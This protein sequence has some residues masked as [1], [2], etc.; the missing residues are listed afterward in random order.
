MGAQRAGTTWWYGLLA[1][2]P[3]IFHSPGRPKELHYFDGFWNHPL[4]PADVALYE[5]YFPRPPGA[6][7][8]EWTPR[9]MYDWWTPRLLELAA[10]HSR[11]LVLLRDPVD[12]YRSGLRLEST[13]RRKPND[14]SSASARGLYHR[15]LAYLLRHFDRDQLLVLQ[16]ER[17]S[18]DPRGELRRTFAFLGLDDPGP[19]PGMELRVKQAGAAN[20]KFDRGHL[21]ALVS[22]FSDD[23]ARLFAEFP[24]ID[25]SLWPTAKGLV[26]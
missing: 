22:F 16:Y 18:L 5:R 8:G 14:T 19:L 13:Q 9:Y 12:R 20:E 7:A 15:Q 25:P 21:G 17:C 24:E 2:H 26:R 6:I 3:A 1:S 23:L 4:V 11:L 10:P